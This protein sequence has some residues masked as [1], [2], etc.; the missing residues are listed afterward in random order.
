MKIHF[1]TTRKLSDFVFQEGTSRNKRFRR[2]KNFV[3]L[4]D[5]HPDERAAPS[6][7][8]GPDGVRTQFHNRVTGQYTTELTPLIMYL[9]T[10]AE[11][12]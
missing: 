11:D 10:K 4:F 9:I 3:R 8:S 6:A 12:F 2:D 1:L 7:T 5:R